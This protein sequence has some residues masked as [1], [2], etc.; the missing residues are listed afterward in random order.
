VLL[1]V[2]SDRSYPLPIQSPVTRLPSGAE[3]IV[4][5]E[6]LQ[7]KV[8]RS[9]AT[10]NDVEIHG[11][12]VLHAG[13]LLVE[14][15]LQYL[16]L[17]RPAPA[18][19]K[20]APVLDHWA[21]MGR[22]EEEATAASG[23]FAVLMGRSGAFA[24]DRPTEALAE[25][26]TSPG[27]R[28]VVGRCGLN[29]LEVLVLGEPSSLDA[30][31][32]FLSNRAGQEEETVRWGT[33]WF[34]NHGATAEELWSV[35]IDRLLGLEPQDRNEF[36]WSDPCMTRLR[37]LASRWSRRAGLVL[38]GVEGVGRESLAL[39][40]RGASAPDAPF[41]VHRAARF[42]RARWLEDVTRAAGGALHVRRP[43]ILPASEQQA[44][45]SANAF[46]PSVGVTSIDAWRLGGDRIVVPGLVDRPA[47]V[48][49]I[50]EVALHAVD[51]QL[52]R[53]RSSLRTEARLALHALV[54]SEN[55]RT[56]RNVVIRAALNSTGSEVQLEHLGL[57][58]GAPPT[59]GVRAKVREAER[60]EIE[61]V[62]H[63]SGW[64]VTEAARR[65]KLP[66]R[67]LVYRMARLGLRRP[68]GLR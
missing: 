40:A 45:W 36:V 50:A 15:D 18:G 30:L 26:S 8:G 12:T 51:V 38:I 7:L 35:A 63:G 14:G 22:L 23:P 57:S 55:V 42:D 54:A 68:G 32:E 48:E 62:L 46:R 34:P 66:R 24:S 3:V 31:K 9:R 17:P 33:A 11:A 56:L 47:D 16:V 65:M 52:G 61:S 10:V 64:N 60:R 67:T 49:P 20:P 41:V 19:P 5:A 59:S 13:D 44:F 58:S 6:R 1:V 43:E 25:F 53:R 2:G 21:W 39:C 4:D 29:T 27:S 37:E 28:H